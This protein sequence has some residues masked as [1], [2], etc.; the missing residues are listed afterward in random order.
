MNK[1][2]NESRLLRDSALPRFPGLMAGGTPVTHTVEVIGCSL[3]TLKYLGEALSKQ[4]QAT[5][6]GEEWRGAG[7]RK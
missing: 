4:L 3:I 1:R 7:E 5:A 2:M 6:D